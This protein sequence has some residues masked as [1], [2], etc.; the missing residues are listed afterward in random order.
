MKAIP[1]FL[2]GA[3][4]STAGMQKRRALF[5]WPE[6]NLVV[7]SDCVS[8]I[9]KTSSKDDDRSMISSIIK[10]IKEEGMEVLVQDM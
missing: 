3:L 6:M 10:D 8:V 1:S 2:H 4:C 9:D 7:E 5:C